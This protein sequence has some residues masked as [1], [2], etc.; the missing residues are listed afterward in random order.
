MSVDD[1]DDANRFDIIDAL[2]ES[3]D[4]K[5]TDP[6]EVFAHLCTYVA[7]IER[8]AFTQRAGFRVADNQAVHEGV[9][10]DI[11]EWYSWY[12]GPNCNHG[13]DENCQSRTHAEFPLWRLRPVGEA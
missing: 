9:V 10:H 6:R 1:I 12:E 7:S 11:E 8:Q 4:I 2:R 13:P 3:F 5:P